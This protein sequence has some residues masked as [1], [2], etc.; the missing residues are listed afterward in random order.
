MI[1]TFV[2]PVIR[3]AYGLLSAI[4]KPN[5]MLYCIYQI[6]KITYDFFRCLLVRHH[7][8]MLLT[9]H[10]LEASYITLHNNEPS[11]CLVVRLRW[12]GIPLCQCLY[13]IWGSLQLS[14]RDTVRL[15]LLSASKTHLFEFS[16]NNKAVFDNAFP[17]L[18]RLVFL[19]YCMDLEQTFLNQDWCYDW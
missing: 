17:I 13:C 6:T 10:L 8:Q 19:L 3:I 4:S 7:A 16:H 2:S 5:I 11:V 1:S 15:R 14:S 9:W 18:T 12:P